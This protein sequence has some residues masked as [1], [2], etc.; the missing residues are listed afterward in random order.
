[1]HGARVLVVEDDELVRLGIRYALAKAG[2]RVIEARNAA[3]ALAEWEREAGRIDLVVADLFL[4]AGPAVELAEALRAK[5]QRMPFVYI[6]AHPQGLARSRGWIDRDAAFL[7]K[8]FAFE[9][10]VAEVQRALETGDGSRG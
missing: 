5:G 9:D 6:S 10:L 8:P 7:Q 2:C 1:M 4:P 3:E